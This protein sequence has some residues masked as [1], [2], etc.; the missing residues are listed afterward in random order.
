MAA[1][2]PAI[3]ADWDGFKETVENGVQGYRI[4]TLML[5]PGTGDRIAWRFESFQIDYGQYLSAVSQTIHVDIR[6]AVDALV[7][8]AED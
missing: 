6:Q 2:I 5:P 4:R 1:G 3:V 7:R 8:L